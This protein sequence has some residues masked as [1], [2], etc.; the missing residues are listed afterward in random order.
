MSL[1][2]VAL[3]I[4]LGVIAA[5]QIYWTSVVSGMLDRLMSRDLS[6]LAQVQRQGA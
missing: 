2:E 6:E 3:V 5:Q 4:A 1:P